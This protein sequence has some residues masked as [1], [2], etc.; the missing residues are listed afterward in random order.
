VLEALDELPGREVLAHLI[1]GARG[2]LLGAERHR[3]FPDM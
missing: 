1:L 3:P 2:E